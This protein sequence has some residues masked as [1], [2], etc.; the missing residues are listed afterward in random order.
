MASSQVAQSTD[1]QDIV[2]DDAFWF[3]D[4][5][6]IIVT[7]DC[8]FDARPIAFRIHKGVLA[9]HSE[10]FSDL[11]SVP[12]PQPSNPDVLD[13]CPI[14]RT[15]DSSH[16]TRHLLRVLYD[17]WL[18]ADSDQP[19]TF[20]TAAALAR[21]SHKYGI[22]WVYGVAVKRLA[23][24]FTD[25]YSIWNVSR[26]QSTSLLSL[27]PRNA[28]EAVNLFR[29]TDTVKM[30]P[31]ALYLC[32]E[33]DNNVLV[34]GV[35]RDDG[36]LEQ[37]SADDLQRCLDVREELAARKFAHVLSTIEEGAASGCNTP[38]QCTLLV[39]AARPSYVLNANA[40]E[41]PGLRITVSRGSLAQ[42][43]NWSSI[44]NLCKHCRKT[45]LSR[46]QALRRQLWRQLPRV[47]R[48]EIDS[49]DEVA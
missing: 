17:G 32:S 46:E 35:A 39:R 15:T 38:E 42:V 43:F 36:S 10:I 4:G 19:M 37:L 24:V 31:V 5:N 9:R 40:T 20:S 13:G 2:R 33:L 22:L 23:S 41:G 8:S 45:L 47:M 30:L 11:L 25:E 26:G 3:E 44:F 6:I 7:K 12:L 27:Q 18:C 28:I 1:R 16:D 49:W 14:M 48:L 29:T 34:R 21:L